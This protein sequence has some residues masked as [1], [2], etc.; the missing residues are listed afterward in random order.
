MSYQIYIKLQGLRDEGSLTM[1]VSMS[2][3]LFFILFYFILLSHILFWLH[4]M[5]CNTILNIIWS[6]IIKSVYQLIN[7]GL[8]WILN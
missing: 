8:S 7:F 5:I 1:V 2:K 3:L 4:E 6:N